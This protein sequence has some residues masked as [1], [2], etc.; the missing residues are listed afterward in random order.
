MNPKALFVRE[1]TPKTMKRYNLG[2]DG[3]IIQ[4]HNGEYVKYL[5]ALNASVPQ[6][7]QEGFRAFLARRGVDK[8]HS[9]YGAVLHEID[10]LE[11]SESLA[12]EC[13]KEWEKIESIRNESI[14]FA[15]R[16]LVERCDGPEGV[17]SDL[18]NIDTSWA[19][20]VLEGDYSRP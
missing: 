15:L 5:D 12:K 19:H 14:L 10:N 3:L 1:S 9:L 18:S 17:R 2:R 6:D 7:A 16:D 8:Y 13:C 20:A 11:E 4:E